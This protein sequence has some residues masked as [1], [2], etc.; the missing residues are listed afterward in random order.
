[1]T[2][3]VNKDNRQNKVLLVIPYIGQLSN[4]EQF[5]ILTLSR[6]R[7]VEIA[8]VLSDVEQIS[9][10]IK[11][12]HNIHV[13]DIEVVFNRENSII[14]L[15]DLMANPYKLTDMKI[16]HKCLFSIDFD[17]YAAFGFCDVDCM[18]NPEVIDDKLKGLFS[19]IGNQMI[20]GDRGHLMVFGREAYSLMVKVML[21]A[22][23]VIIKRKNVDIFHSSHHFALDE[24][25]FL[26]R[27]LTTLSE[28][29]LVAWQPSFFRPILDLSYKRVNPQVSE[30]RLKF[31]LSEN[32]IYEGLEVSDLGY[33]HFQKRYIRDVEQPADYFNKYCFVDSFGN[34][35][36]TTEA[37]DF[38]T[39]RATKPTKLA[40]FWGGYVIPR[41][42]DRYRNHGCL[43]KLQL[44][45]QDIR[46]SLKMAR[47]D[48]N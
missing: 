22:R 42:R 28:L 32:A 3:E 33:I 24:F 31:R 9:A 35:A 18:Y 25:L 46:E 10:D 21:A 17:S 26:H 13:Y 7:I 37:V 16:F 19:S 20:G 29:G 6:S 1:M 30:T 39:N 47:I 8:L 2:D 48:E 36:F 11:S 34:I 4:F 44:T 40:Y 43:P 12:K 14:K 15:N 27:V 41:L 5:S 38:C 23:Q 45:Q